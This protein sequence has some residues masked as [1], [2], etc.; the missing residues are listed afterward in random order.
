LIPLIEKKTFIYVE[1]K[2][3]KPCSRLSTARG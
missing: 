3:V 1:N 2:I